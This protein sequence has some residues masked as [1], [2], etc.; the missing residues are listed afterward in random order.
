[1]FR[2]L[3]FALAVLVGVFAGNAPAW[4]GLHFR[5][6]TAEKVYVAVAYAESGNVWQ[7]RGWYGVEPGQR[8]EVVT[9][10]LRQRFYYYN[11]NSAS[12]RTLWEGPDYFYVHPTDAFTIY[13]VDGTYGTLPYGATMKGFRT[14]DTGE[15]RDFT[16]NLT[17]SSTK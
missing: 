13:R 5:N 4:A 8:F 15:Y 17:P 3:C 12:H 6:Y 16:L 11:A 2:K 9:G 7:V 14:I 10:D 1:M